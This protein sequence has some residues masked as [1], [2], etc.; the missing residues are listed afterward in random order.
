MVKI[1]EHCIRCGLCIDLYP[2]LFSF[3]CAE[4]RIDI[5]DEAQQEARREDALS[6]AADCPVG[7][8]AV[9]K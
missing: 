7:A 9:T 8:I 1:A 4:D 3:N 5:L 2:A 6:A